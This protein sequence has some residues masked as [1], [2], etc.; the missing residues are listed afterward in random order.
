M[1]PQ[2]PD[3]GAAMPDAGMSMPDAGGGG[4]MPDVMPPRRD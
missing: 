4:G 2:M 3:G 1:A